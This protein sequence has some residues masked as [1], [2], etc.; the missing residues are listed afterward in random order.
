MFQ[1]VSG[2]VFRAIE[3]APS[4]ILTLDVLESMRLCGTATLK[5]TL[6]R[7]ARKGAIMGLKRG[8]YAALPLK[9]GFAAAQ[10]TFNG[11]LGFSTALYLHRIIP[12]QPFSITVV[13]RATS[14]VKPFGHYEFRAVALKDKA[15]G[16]EQKGGYTVSTRA[17]T[18]FDCL[19]LPQYSIGHEKLLEAYAEAGLSANEWR[20][21]DGYAKRFAGK[22]MA[23][24]VREVKKRLVEKGK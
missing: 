20:E 21:F 12:E 8:T 14:A 18:L 23:K 15:V 7:L 4:G 2:Q 1:S 11:Y 24:E 22:R 16:F 17:K 10:A 6:S 5:T 3:M 9:D 13:T 19:Y